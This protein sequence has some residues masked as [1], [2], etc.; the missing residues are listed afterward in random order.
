MKKNHLKMFGFLAV[1]ILLIAGCQKEI[2]EANP[3]TNDPDNAAA[4]GFHQDDCRLLSETSELGQ[5]AYTY[6]NRGLLDEYTVSFVE[7][8]HLKMQ[9]D[10]KGHLIKSLFY[11]GDELL[12]TIFFFYWGD[13][14][15]K[16]TW[17][18]GSNV[19]V[20]EVFHSYNRNGRV[21]RSRSFMQDYMSIYS[22]TPDGGSVDG[23]KF[24][25]GG[26]LNY[27]QRF[28]YLSPHH[29][30][31][32]LARP[33]LVYDFIS[34]NGWWTESNW[35]STSEKG[36]SYDEN[37][38]NPQVLVDQDPHKSIVQFNRHNYVTATDF[39]DNL[40]QDYVH[41]RFVY[42]NCGPEDENDIAKSSQK[43]PAINS[44]TTSPLRLLRIGSKK[45]IKDQ[46]KQLRDQY[47]KQIITP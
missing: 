47:L 21:W 24:Y 40:T 22:Y 6:N 17:Y 36:I 32:N 13:R 10:H 34:P 16:E 11:S 9:Y 1:T 28:T 44:N 30:N 14:L 20:D 26:K 12:N 33:G 7:N 31:P 27:E 29:R 23:W 19:K 5:Y 41:F 38:M 46:L 3:V 2:K 43:L 39:Y 8:G 18:D 4:G 25:F 37:G 15:V 35:Y 45:S 42:E